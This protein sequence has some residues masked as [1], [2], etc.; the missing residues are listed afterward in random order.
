MLNELLKD[1]RTGQD[2]TQIGSFILGG[3]TK[4]GTYSQAIQEL[5]KRIRGLRQMITSRDLLLIDKEEVEERINGD[6]ERDA[7]RAVIELRSMMGQLEES[8]RGIRDTKREAA[9]FY[10][11]AADLKK[12]LGEITE[13]RRAELDRQEWR[14][15]HIK[16]AMIGKLTTGRVDD[17]VL[18]NLTSIPTAERQE[19]L[20]V[21][22]DDAKIISI[23]E[24]SE[25]GLSY[26][27]ECSDDD[28]RVIEEISG[29]NQ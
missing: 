22:K 28:V 15:Y 23:L 27:L 18:K 14:W 2:S 20:S 24:E 19:W 13:E 3:M 25:Y 26:A 6:D 8:E 21:M 12:V 11:V 9:M 4:W 7:R 10:R 17:I 16:R 1:H 29:G 5:Y